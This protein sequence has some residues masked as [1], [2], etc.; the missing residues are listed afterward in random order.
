MGEDALE[1]M[2]RIV[3]LCLELGI[4]TFDHA[5]IY[6]NYQC[7]ELFGKVISQKTFKRENIVLFTKCGLKVPHEGNPGVRIKHYDTSGEHIQKSVE[8][9]LRKL[10][11]DYIDIFLLDHLDPS[12]LLGHVAVSAVRR[13]GSDRLT[14]CPDHVEA[15]TV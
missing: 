13:R 12:G 9:S 10:N 8:N 1:R 7:E 5:D 2:E 11:T 4:N 15:S 6:G 14:G 3:N